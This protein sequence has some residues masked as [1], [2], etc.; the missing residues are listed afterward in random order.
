MSGAAGINLPSVTLRSRELSLLRSISE[1]TEPLESNPDERR[2][3]HWLGLI[4][5]KIVAPDNLRELKAQERDAV[6]RIR[7]HLAEG[8]YDRARDICW[9]AKEAVR[10]TAPAKRFFI[11]AKGILILRQS[12]KLDAPQLQGGAQTTETGE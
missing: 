12:L 3:L 4:E 11:T 1:G 10:K 6:A 5:Q 7:K 8:E 9:Q 2:K